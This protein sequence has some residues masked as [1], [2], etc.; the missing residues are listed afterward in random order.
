MIKTSEKLIEISKALNA[1]QGDITGAKAD[2]VNPFFKS[3]YADLQSLWTAL[4]GPLLKHGLSIVQLTSHEDG[5][6]WFVVTRILHS[7]GEWLEGYFPIVA[8]K[9]RDPQAFGSAVSYA[10]R[11]SLAAAVGM[12]DRDDDAEAAMDRPKPDLHPQNATHLLKA[13]NEGTSG[14]P[15]LGECPDCGSKMSKSKYAPFN[16][17]CYPCSQKKKKSTKFTEDD[18]PF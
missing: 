14:I 8:A 18:L 7:S 9:E 13:A 2:S 12:Y 10:R 1:L 4:K 3:H 11:Y 15:R 5:M 16:D 6:G 17:Y